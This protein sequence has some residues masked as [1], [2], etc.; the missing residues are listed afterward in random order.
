MWEKV[1]IR[2]NSICDEF[3]FYPPK[4][5]YHEPLSS[6]GF[7]PNNLKLKCFTADDQ[8]VKICCVVFY[9]SKKQEDIFS[10]TI[11]TIVHDIGNLSVRLIIESVNLSDIQIYEIEKRTKE[12]VDE[13]INEWGYECTRFEIKILE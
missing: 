11:E 10:S 1:N 4:H 13:K 8:V 2:K 9:R 6:I 3:Q 5:F 12:V 7:Y